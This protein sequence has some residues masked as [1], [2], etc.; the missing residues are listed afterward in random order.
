MRAF[1]LFAGPLIRCRLI[2]LG[3][4]DHVLLVTMHHIVADGWSLPVWAREFSEI[5]RARVDGRNPSLPPLPIQYVDYAV[6]QQNRF[7]DESMHEQIEYWEGQLSGAP[8]VLEIPT[9]RRRP[10]RQ[11]FVGSR[12]GVEID[13]QL[14]EALVDLSRR[15]G[16]TLFMTLFG[17]WATLLSRLSG[18]EDVVVG[19]V[20]ANRMCDEVQPLC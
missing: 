7:A 17:A 19:T 6:W 11:S 10:N 16:T 9:D 8:S 4:E 14:T 1:D 20:T 12:V 15:H 5:Y 2:I 18:Q 13:E 3:P